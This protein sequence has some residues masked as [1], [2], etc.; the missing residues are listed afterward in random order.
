M[1]EEAEEEAASENGV[2][3]DDSQEGT[4]SDQATIGLLQLSIYVVQNR[5][6][7]T[8]KSRWD[9]TNKGNYHL[10]LCMPFVGLAPVRPFR[11][12]MAVLYH[13]NGRLQRAYSDN[14]TI[15]QAENNCKH[16][17]NPNLYKKLILK[18]PKCPWHDHNNLSYMRSP[19]RY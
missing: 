5:H 8:Q 16:C 13:V 19:D 15:T 11:P 10:K 4:D 17:E 6:V 12:N 18:C 9:K 14:T 1:E 7:G 2:E 3:A